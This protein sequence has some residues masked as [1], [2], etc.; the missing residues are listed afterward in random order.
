MGTP[1]LILLKTKRS[2]DSR[3]LHSFI[4]KR[5]NSISK[6]GNMLTPAV[7][8]FPWFAGNEIVLGDEH[9]MNPIRGTITEPDTTPLTNSEATFDP[10]LGWEG[11][12]KERE[13]AKWTEEEMEA[14]RIPPWKRDYCAHLIAPLKKCLNQNHPAFGRCLPEKEDYQ[15]CQQNEQL[16]RIKEWERE[17]RLRLRQK[18]LEVQAAA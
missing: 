13:P 6:M 4:Y 8:V 1:Y 16:L 7:M 12:R 5:K 10:Q 17:R 15:H 14:M 9:M 11:Q 18:A 2:Q 3:R